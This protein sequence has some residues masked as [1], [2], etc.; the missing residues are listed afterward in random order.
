MWNF[1]SMISYGLLYAMLP[2]LKK[3]YSKEDMIRIGDRLLEYFNTNPYNASIVLGIMTR[4]EIEA[5]IKEEDLSS[6]IE[7]VKLNLMGPLAALGDSFFWWCLR[8][9][10]VV[11]GISLMLVA[12]HVDLR[13]G[14]LAVLSFLFAF[15]WFHLRVRVIG[16][17]S[18][19][20]EGLHSIRI[21][22]SLEMQ[23][24]MKK[25]FRLTFVTLG[26]IAAYII[27]NGN[28]YL[29]GSGFIE[30]TINRITMFVVS[31]V[32]ITI[33]TRIYE[34]KRSVILLI[35]ANIFFSVIIYYFKIFD[36]LFE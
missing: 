33:F 11:I 5:H 3:F 15:N 18:G 34:W 4:L 25:M 26:I 9:F 7:S 13:L 12:L 20:K 6:R 21:L 1:N 27:L 23:S 8:P 36:F 16:F 24:L 22:Q 29:S 30:G 32:L 10:S 19:L 14:I 2:V 35:I 17:F 28:F 31:V